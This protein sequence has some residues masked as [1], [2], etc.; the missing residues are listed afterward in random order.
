VTTQAQTLGLGKFA[1]WGFTLKHPDD[2]VVELRHE[3]KFVARFS[4]LGATEES[5][6]AECTRHLVMKHGWE[7]NHK[8]SFLPQAR[9]KRRAAIDERVK[10]SGHA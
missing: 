10:G 4:Q 2:H 9:I 3:G 6:Q 5:L 8:V 7:N 1:C